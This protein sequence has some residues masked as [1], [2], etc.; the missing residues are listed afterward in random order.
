[1]AH[2]SHR[3]KRLRQNEKKKATNLSAKKTLKKATK[4]FLVLVNDKKTGEAKEN[5]KKI[6]SAYATTA[7]RGIIN[8]KR[9]SRK[10]SRLAKK[11]NALAAA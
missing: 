5:L 8:K 2:H 3:L 4:D 11:V 6:T 10:I 9:A 1:M 7:K